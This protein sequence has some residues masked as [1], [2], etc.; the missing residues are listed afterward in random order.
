MMEM[1]GKTMRQVSK[2]EFMATYNNLVYE[3]TQIMR[4]LKTTI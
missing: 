3:N 2:V 4:Q 1:V